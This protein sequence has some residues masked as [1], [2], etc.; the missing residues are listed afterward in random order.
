M[1]AHAYWR[2][3]FKR[4]IEFFLEGERIAREVHDGLQELAA[5]SFQSLAHA[6]LGEWGLALESLNQGMKKARERNNKFIIARLTNSL[7]WF[8]RELGDMTKALEQ[9]QMG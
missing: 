7:G 4:A 2:G 8:Y 6:G 9:D 1:G 5:L 3:E